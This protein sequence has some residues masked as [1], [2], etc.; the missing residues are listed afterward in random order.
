MREHRKLKCACRVDLQSMTE[1]VQPGSATQT[2]S[3]GD[4]DISQI[5][6]IYK[7]YCSGPCE[8]NARRYNQRFSINAPPPPSSNVDHVTCEIQFYMIGRFFRT[9]E[10]RLHPSTLHFGGRGA[11]ANFMARLMDRAFFSH[12]PVHVED[13]IS[14]FIKAVTCIKSLEHLV[15]Q[16]HMYIS[17][18]PLLESIDTNADSN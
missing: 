10:I 1:C 3:R 5:K 12:G 18:H 2:T 15:Q 8:K 6:P 16:L 4:Q 14:T 9:L 17:I 11:L 7:L 13:I